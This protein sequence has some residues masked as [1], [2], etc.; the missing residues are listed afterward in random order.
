MDCNFETPDQCAWNVVPPS[1]DRKVA[2]DNLIAYLD[3]N[4]IPIICQSDQSLK[5]EC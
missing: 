5:Y 2:R 4:D 1:T 3:K